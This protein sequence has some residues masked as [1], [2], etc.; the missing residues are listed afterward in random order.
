MRPLK[1]TQPLR[2]KRLRPTMRT[3]M[4]QL[5]HFLDAIQTENL[6]TVGALGRL[7]H[8]ILAHETFKGL[9]YLAHGVLL[10]DEIANPHTRLL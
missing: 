10:V 4:P 6:L 8:Q 7:D 9:L 2:L 5:D 1:R 3:L